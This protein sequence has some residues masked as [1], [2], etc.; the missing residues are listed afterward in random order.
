MFA[1]LFCLHSLCMSANFVAASL[2]TSSFHDLHHLVIPENIH[3]SP[4]EG[5]E[6]NPPTPF[7]R[8]DTQ[9]FLPSPSGRQTF[10]PWGQPRT[11][12]LAW[13]R[14]CHGGSVD[15]FLIDPL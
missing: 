15:L 12:A 4:T 8:P 2:I 3:S 11:Q 9:M 1:G 10:P 7:R 5:L 6:I 13:V 14:G